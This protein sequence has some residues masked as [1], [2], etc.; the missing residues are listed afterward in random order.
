MLVLDSSFTK[1]DVQAINHFVNIAVQ[2]ERQRI[3]NGVDSIEAQ[4]HAT[5]TPLY[6]D[7]LLGLFRDLVEDLNPPRRFRDVS[8]GE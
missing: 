2:K 8:N 5:K 7:T 1:D 6:Q 4:S 3:L